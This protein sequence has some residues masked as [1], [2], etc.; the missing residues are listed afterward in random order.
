MSGFQGCPQGGVPLQPIL[1]LT[2]LFE[3]TDDDAL[4][5]L[6]KKRY[7]TAWRTTGQR[8]ELIGVVLAHSSLY[9]MHDV[10]QEIRHILNLEI[11]IFF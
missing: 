5:A 9:N 7:D 10:C 8:K 1:L 2:K 4:G 11:Y 6:C 3:L